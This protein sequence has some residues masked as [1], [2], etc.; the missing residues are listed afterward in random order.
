MERLYSTTYIIFME[1]VESQKIKH[2]LSESTFL[3]LQPARDE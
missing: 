2:V 1:F 3:E